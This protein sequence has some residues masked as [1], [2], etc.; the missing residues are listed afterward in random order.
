MRSPKGF[1]I[2]DS[3]LMLRRCCLA[4]RKVQG[5]SF[6]QDRAMRHRVFQPRSGGPV[7]AI[8][9][10]FRALNRRRC[11]P[12]VDYRHRA[13]WYAPTALENFK[14]GRRYYNSVPPTAAADEGLLFAYH[15]FC[16]LNPTFQFLLP[17]I[18][19]AS[20]SPAYRLSCRR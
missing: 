8:R 14:W 11:V 13:D 9:S 4:G 15:Q 6:Q 17:Y 12:A 10:L 16:I 18:P 7:V 5:P 2:P 20:Q 1:S 3:V 19:S